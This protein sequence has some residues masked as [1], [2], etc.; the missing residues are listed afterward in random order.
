MNWTAAERTFPAVWLLL[1]FVLG[2]V[3]CPAIEKAA[4]S[5]PDRGGAP[6]LSPGP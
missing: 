2:I 4:Q 5:K 6:L 1:I 3:V